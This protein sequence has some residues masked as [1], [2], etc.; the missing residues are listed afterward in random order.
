MNAANVVWI[1]MFY[2]VLAFPP[3]ALSQVRQVEPRPRQQLPPDETDSNAPPQVRQVAPRESAL[4]AM[5]SRS[6]HQQASRYQ[7]RQQIP[8]RWRL[9]IRDAVSP[10]GVRVRS[11]HQ[12]TPASDQLG[13]ETGDYIL[14]VQGYP[15]GYYQGT[16]YD[17]SDL[18]N[19]SADPQ[20]WVNLNIWDHRTGRE[21]PYWVRLQRR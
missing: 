1:V 5:M 17:L 14:D 13:L 19:M 8:R 11:V 15:V 21:A 20:G 7:M 12:N 4:Q 3:A 16:Y 18:L 9:G 2:A 10:L 6:T